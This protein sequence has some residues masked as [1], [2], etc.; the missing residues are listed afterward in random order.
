MI[1][2]HNTRYYNTA[3]ALCMLVRQG[4][5]HTEYVQVIAFP[6]QQRLRNGTIISWLLVHC[7]YCFVLAFENF[8]VDLQ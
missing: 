8:A 1:Q 5:R 6:R 7:L 4:Y 2:T 3:H